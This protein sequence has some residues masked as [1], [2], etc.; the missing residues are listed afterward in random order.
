MAGRLAVTYRRQLWAV[1]DGSIDLESESLQVRAATTQDAAERGSLE[2]ASEREAIQRAGASARMLVEA[3]PGTGKTEMAAL[4]LA[5]LIRSELS[6]GQVLVLSFSRSA[7]RTLT[8]RLA[9]VT[10]ADPQVLEELRHVSIRTFDSWAFRMLRLLG[11]QP[12]VLLARD[13]D[14]NIAE[15][16]ALMASPRR[17]DVRALIGDRRHLIVDE[18]QDLPGV[19]GELV[20]ELLSLLAPPGVPGCGFTILGDPA[21]AIYGFAARLNGASA[22]PGPIEYWNRVQDLYGAALQLRVLHRNY[23]AEATLAELSA[24]LRAVLLSDRPEHEK[25]RRI[26][27]AVSALPEAPEAPGPAWLS[28]GQPGSRAVLTRTN[29]E[30]LRVLQKIVGSAVEGPPT[31]V[32]L[33]ACS[34]ATLP[35]AWIGA[36]LR[37]LRSSNLTR[38]QFG[39]IYSHLTGLWD[40]DTS[41]KLGLPPESGA[42]TRLALASGAPEDAASID[43]AELRLRMNWPDTFPDDQPISEEGVIVTTIHQSKGMEFDIVTILDSA[44]EEDEEKSAGDD[45]EE[46]VIASSPVEEAN[47]A[48]V[49]VT[50]AGRAL[51]R[52][53]R[54]EIFQAPTS[55]PFPG[56]RRR[57]CSWRNGWMNMEMGL[58]GDIDAF[59]F[60]DPAMHGGADGV[61]KM[62][63][64][65]LRNARRL[66]GHKVMLCKHVTDRKAIWHIH[67]QN[68]NQPDRLIG[69]TAPQLTYDLLHVLHGRGYGL[70]RTIMNLRIAAVGTVAAEGDLALEEPDRTSRLWL[71]ISLFGTGD[72]RT[73]KR[74]QA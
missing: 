62:Q 35:P 8:Q 50:R 34:F 48:Y 71:G 25:L 7:V 31:P 69:C 23:R 59:G 53:T 27:E 1:S 46:G 22:F 41:A 52:F 55:W 32:R 44:R 49:A 21:Q 40:E 43:V 10:R 6:P 60:A 18:F 28:G 70:P 2:D 45:L 24:N 42:W 61:E 51:Y 72:F 39:R 47:V 12:S 11:R 15:L 37:K 29:G 56:E 20:L 63:D 5:G 33:R 67:L 68:G 4:R 9:R 64:Y 58:R 17:D 30:A 19:R 66:E 13:H 54:D 74:E 26:R 38:S 57:L 3:G 16:T 14:A 73:K 36:L 65:L